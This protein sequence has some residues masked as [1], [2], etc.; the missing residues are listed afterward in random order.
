MKNE[1]G[2]ERRWRGDKRDA[3]RGEMGRVRERTRSGGT[4]EGAACAAHLSQH[5][6]HTAR[7]GRPTRP[8]GNKG[9]GAR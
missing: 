1:G 2:E 9:T 7:R 5:L 6:P 4:R 3:A 8:E